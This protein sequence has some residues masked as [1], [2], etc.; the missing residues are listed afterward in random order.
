MHRIT[1]HKLS[2]LPCPLI[3]LTFLLLNG[4]TGHRSPGNR[5]ENITKS[6]FFRFAELMVGFQ[7]I[8]LP[9]IIQLSDKTQNILQKA[10]NSQTQPPKKQKFRKAANKKSYKME[11]ITLHE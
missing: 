8:T 7:L 10:K 5:D 6:S 2:P 11:I 3:K 4:P 9:L 1:E